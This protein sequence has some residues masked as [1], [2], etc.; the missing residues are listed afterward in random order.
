MHLFM[1]GSVA[2][3]GFGRRFLFF[4][5]FFERNKHLSKRRDATSISGRRDDIKPITSIGLCCQ[6][7]SHSGCVPKRC[8]PLYVWFTITPHSFCVLW[9]KIPVWAVTSYQNTIFLKEN[10]LKK[11]LSV[12]FFFQKRPKLFPLTLQKSKS[13]VLWPHKCLDLLPVRPNWV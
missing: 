11:A 12:P 1:S 3:V 10:Y 13:S 4:S 7:L 2:L 6:F 8:I 5:F 9:I